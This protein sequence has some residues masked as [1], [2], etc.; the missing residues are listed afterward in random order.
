[1][2]PRCSSGS[3]RRHV[4]I[5]VHVTLQMLLLNAECLVSLQ[6]AHDVV[7]LAEEGVPIIQSL[8]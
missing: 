7:S 8:L 5:V 1:M 4:S 6:L 2:A 3:L